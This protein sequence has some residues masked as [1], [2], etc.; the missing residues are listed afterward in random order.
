M[1]REIKFRGLRID[2]KGW[3]YGSLAYFFENPN[4]ACIMPRCYFGTR[5]FGETDSQGKPIIDDEMALGGFI[6]V[7]SETVGQFTNE[8]DKNGLEIY[9]GDIVKCGYGIGTVVFH[10]GCFMVKWQDDSY[11]ELLYSK[12]GIY[13]RIDSELFEI[14]INL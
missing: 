14:I 13:K 1:E 11:M 10:A 12:D 2:G 3:V 8:L 5:D 6:N 9:E 7:K 4:N